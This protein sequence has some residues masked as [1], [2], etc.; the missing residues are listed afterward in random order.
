MVASDRGKYFMWEAMGSYLA[1][2]PPTL[3][4]HMFDFAAKAIIIKV[5]SCTKYKDRCRKPLG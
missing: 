2:V 3:I 1:L 4:N 5:I